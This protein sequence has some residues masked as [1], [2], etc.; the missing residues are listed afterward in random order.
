MGEVMKKQKMFGLQW[1][2]FVGCVRTAGLHCRNR[3]RPPQPAARSGRDEVMKKQKMF[4]LQWRGSNHVEAVEARAKTIRFFV[5]QAYDGDD[6]MK[7]WRLAMKKGARV[8][9]V[10]VSL[11]G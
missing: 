4:G 8:V 9:P 6:P 5:G 7:G 10:W 3:R 2:G 1:R 11:R